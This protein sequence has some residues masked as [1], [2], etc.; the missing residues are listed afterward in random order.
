MNEANTFDSAAIERL[1]KLGGDKFTTDMIDLFFSYGGQKV[2]EARQA[3]LAGDLAGV[4]AAAHPLKSSAGNVGALRVQ[5]LAAGLEQSAKTG[6]VAAVTGQIGE[7]EQAYA[8]AKTRLEAEKAR[9]KPAV[10]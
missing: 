5:A 2:A 1:R 7:F 9:L 8:E 6:D 3:Q 10:T 4:A